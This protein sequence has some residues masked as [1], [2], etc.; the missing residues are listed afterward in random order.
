MGFS[1][2]IVMQLAPVNFRLFLSTQKDT[3]HPLAQIQIEKKKRWNYMC[4]KYEA[5]LQI[6]F[7]FRATIEI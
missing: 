1:V 5:S 6:I 3:L 2:L 4:I 7:W